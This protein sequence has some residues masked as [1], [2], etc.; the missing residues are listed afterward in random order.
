MGAA[1]VVVT[2]AAELVGGSEAVVVAGSDADVDGTG[3]V[4]EA[5]ER[6]ETGVRRGGGRGVSA[7]A[8]K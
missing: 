6:E 1:E 4:V 3:N 8:A 7:V 5:L 2:G